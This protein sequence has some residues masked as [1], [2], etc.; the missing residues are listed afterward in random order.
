MKAATSEALLSG[1]GRELVPVIKAL[2]RD[3]RFAG[4][5]VLLR[6]PP[7]ITTRLL[8]AN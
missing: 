4:I 2:D 6:A 7:S 1:P 5:A 8:G 3:W